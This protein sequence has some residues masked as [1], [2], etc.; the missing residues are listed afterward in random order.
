MSR[1]RAFAICCAFALVAPAART[2]RAQDLLADAA[3]ARVQAEILVDMESAALP[4]VLRP[5]QEHLVPSVESWVAQRSTLDTILEGDVVEMERVAMAL[6]QARGLANNFADAEAI[7][8]LSGAL[9]RAA[10]QSTIPGIASLYAELELQLGIALARVN[11]NQ[12]A[13]QSLLRSVVI[14]PS[15]VVGDAEAAP[16]FVA[17]ARA[18]SASTSELPRTRIEVTCL[19]IGARVFLDDVDRGAC[20]SPVSVSLATIVGRHFLRVSD[21]AHVPYGVLLDAFSGEPTRVHVALRPDENRVL[22]QEADAAARAG[23][24]EL[25]GEKISLLAA[26][27]GASP[28]VWLR[29]RAHSPRGRNVFSEVSVDDIRHFGVER[30]EGESPRMFTNALAAREWLAEALPPP[31]RPHT[32]F[33]EGWFPPVVTL[34]ATVLFVGIGITASEQRPPPAPVIFIDPSG[35]P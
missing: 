19:P 28:I 35:L 25:L 1:S 27:L 4:P 9:R 7:A 10:D 23:N 16:G 21:I 33:D 26:R 14:D 22:A 31:P 18:T 17:R 6:S 15:R 32:V 2:A 30:A 34:V 3:D 13:S 24:E 20:A 29:H 5:N 8:V 12:I 11:L